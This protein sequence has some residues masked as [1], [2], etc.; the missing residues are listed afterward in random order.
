M[1]HPPQTFKK[2][3]QIDFVSCSGKYLGIFSWKIETNRRR[4]TSPQNVHWIF[5][6]FYLIAKI[7]HKSKWSTTLF[8]FDSFCRLFKVLSLTHSG[9]DL[10]RRAFTY[11]KSLTVKCV[12]KC[13]NLIHHIQWVNA[14]AVCEPLF[15]L[16][17]FLSVLNF[18]IAHKKNIIIDVNCRRYPIEIVWEN[19]IE[20][21]SKRSY[22]IYDCM[23]NF[24]LLAVAAI[25]IFTFNFCSII[26]IE[27]WKCWTRQRM[28]DWS[29]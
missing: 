4:F 16:I 21:Y 24:N 1:L 14:R 28:K 10:N 23:S 18:R 5:F 7:S 15:F 20:I 12:W 27:F 9:F 11:V 6:A 22:Y 13:T 26:S 29:V 8:P 17:I 3:L 19:N 25:K 2:I